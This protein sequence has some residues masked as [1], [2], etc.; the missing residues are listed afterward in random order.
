MPSPFIASILEWETIYVEWIIRSHS[1]AGY[2]PQVSFLRGLPLGKMLK[3]KTDF[4]RAVLI[5]KVKPW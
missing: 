2:L 4:C 5:V 3:D 1:I